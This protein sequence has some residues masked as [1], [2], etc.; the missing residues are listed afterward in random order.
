MLL[1]TMNYDYD[2]QTRHGCRRKRRLINKIQRRWFVTWISV[3]CRSSLRIRRSGRTV[4]SCTRRWWSEARVCTNCGRRAGTR[5]TRPAP[6]WTWWPESLHWCRRG[7]ECTA[8]RGEMMNG[9]CSLLSS[10]DTTDAEAAAALTSWFK[11]N[12]SRFSRWL[13]HPVAAVCSCQ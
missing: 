9:S 6:W 8:C 2:I 3:S 10:S 7:P 12:S 4:W 5:A 1:W 13:S 11:N